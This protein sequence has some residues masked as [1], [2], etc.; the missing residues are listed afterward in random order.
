MVLVVAHASSSSS[1][2]MDAVR[3]CWQG[4]DPGME[5]EQHAVKW[6]INS[7]DGDVCCM[8]PGSTESWF[9]WGAL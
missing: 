6:D 7:N 4:F 9:I 8:E 5:G 1:S 2:M 3:C